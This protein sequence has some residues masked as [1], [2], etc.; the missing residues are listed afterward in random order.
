MSTVEDKENQQP[1]SQPSQAKTSPKKKRGRP[2]G[3]QNKPKS[4]VAGEKSEVTTTT[5]IAKNKKLL[6]T[7]QSP[8]TPAPQQPA[9][10]V[11]QQMHIHGSSPTLLLQCHPLLCQILL[12]SAKPSPT[13]PNPPLLSQTLPSPTLLNPPLLSPTLPHSPLPCP[14]LP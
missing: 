5:K 6:K 1:P 11:S 10:S 4:S 14:P 13:L 2:L 12:Y 7:V 3:S 8:L 9:T